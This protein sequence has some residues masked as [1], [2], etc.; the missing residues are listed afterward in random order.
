MSASVITIESSNREP[1]PAAPDVDRAL[2]S[3]VAWTAAAKW[4]TQLLGWASTIAVARM[5]SPDDY[6]LV[7]MATVY[8]GLVGLLSEFGLGASVV[9][10][11]DLSQAQIAQLNALAALLG[12]AASLVSCAAAPA[13]GRFFGSD[14][15]PAVVA[16]M[17]TTF[18]IAG[19][20]VV[21]QALLQ[22]ELR[23][24]LLAAFET[25]QALVLA[26]SMVLF[27]ALGLRYWTLV[28]G[29][30]LSSVVATALPLLWRP[31][32][33]ALPRLSETRRAITVSTHL[34]VARL[35]WWAQ[36]N[37]D[38]L[39]VGKVLG[40]TVLGAYS[41][42]L[43]VASVPVEKVT[44][45]VGR[46]T[47]AVFSVVQ[48]DAAAMRRYLLRLTSGISLVTFPAAL[49][50]ALVAD[51]FVRVVLG[52]GWAGAV[53]PLRI[54]AAYATLRSVTPLLGHVLTVTGGT[55]FAMRVGIAS[56]VVLPAGFYLGSRWGAGGVAAAW[57]LLDPFLVAPV[58]WRVCRTLGL[59]FRDYLA[60]LRPA[61]TGCVAMVALV[62][63]VRHAAGDATPVA[64]FAASVASGAATYL[65]TV[66]AL[67]GEL[68]R[69]Y[70]ARVRALAPGRRA[71]AVAPAAEE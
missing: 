3:G 36:T 8:L 55:G 69:S 32:P 24:E 67:H 1:D 16:V 22:K 31:H 68:V 38:F 66:W 43:A 57:L 21:P 10:L 11:R 18:L 20:R 6:G 42:A 27:A 64:R 25:A 41:L 28:I 7:G 39:V 51:D 58:Y 70:A 49:G 61:A 56:A 60:A 33:F 65:A 23:F 48:R 4:T 12:L 46:V 14:A 35:T 47:P 19:F 62:L 17:G 54:L 2:V 50:L 26:A 63:L 30:V 44:A 29:A 5:L 13:L 40:Q 45:M 52:A 15:L 59:S 53:V 9:M 34:I 37:A 71:P